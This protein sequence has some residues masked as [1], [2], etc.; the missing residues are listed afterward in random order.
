MSDFAKTLKRLRER[1]KETQT[2]LGEKL[3]LS[4]STISMYENG[5]RTP[6]FDTLMRI[7]NYFNV[8][9]DYLIGREPSKSERQTISP[10]LEDSEYRL[11][12]LY[13]SFN[14]EGREKLLEYA[15]DLDKTSLY[16]KHYTN[17]LEKQEV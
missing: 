13:R 4:K 15:N 12:D 16:K 7:A 14:Q 6:D 10:S 17:H 11:I 5:N 1:Y 3:K 2:T 9:S 8:T